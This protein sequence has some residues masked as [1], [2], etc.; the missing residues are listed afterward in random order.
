ML[1]RCDCSRVRVDV[2]GTGECDGVW[3]G[4]RRHATS[5]AVPG[6]LQHLFKDYMRKKDTNTLK[7]L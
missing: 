2:S 1:P 7:A 4:A 5:D 3:L 6:P